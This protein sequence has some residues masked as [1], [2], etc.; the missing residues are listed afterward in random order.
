MTKYLGPRT[1]LTSMARLL[2][3]PDRR[4]DDVSQWQR[5]VN[6]QLKPSVMYSEFEIV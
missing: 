1:Y 2:I 4:T 3:D 5:I 6:R